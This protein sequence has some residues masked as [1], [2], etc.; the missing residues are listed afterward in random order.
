MGFPGLV[1]LCGAGAARFAAVLSLAT[2]MA[3]CGTRQAVNDTF[4][5][6][7][8]P[9]VSRPAGTNRQILVPEPTALKTLGSDQIVVRL[10]RSELQ[11]LA[12][13]QW[14]DSLPRLVQDR[15]V[16]TFDDTG[17]VRGVGKPGQGLAIDYQLVT[18]LRAFEISTDGPDT[19]VVEI[20][21][22]ILDDRT[23]TVRRQ[24]EFRAVAP[25]Q[26]AGNPAFVAALDAAFA[27]VAADIVGWTLRSI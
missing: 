12:G 27:K 10:S 22:K 26:G 5:L 19:A 16:Q 1:A 14:G 15:L 3:G 13:A 21:A 25:V 9:V 2:I 18:E 24:Q 6:A 23:G 20:F 7:S 11:Y 8:V 4:S 17:R